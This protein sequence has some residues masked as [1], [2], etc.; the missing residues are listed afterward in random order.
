MSISPAKTIRVLL[1]IDG[2]LIVNDDFVH[3]KQSSRTTY[4]N[5]SWTYLFLVLVVSN[6]SK[7]VMSHLSGQTSSQLFGGHFAHY[8]A[9]HSY[10]QRVRAAARLSPRRALL[11]V[12]ECLFFRLFFAFALLN[13]SLFFAL[14][15]NSSF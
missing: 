9:W 11:L 1:V 5:T 2:E 15:L 4:L 8:G 14:L 13:Q 10:A 6:N 3:T 12:H 7:N